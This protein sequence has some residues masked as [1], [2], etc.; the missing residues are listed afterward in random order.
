MKKR[1]KK[2]RPQTKNPMR[3]FSRPRKRAA[4]RRRPTHRN[5]SRRR[6]RNGGGGFAS[7]GI[8]SLKNGFWALVGLV[9]TR[10]LPQ[11]LLKEKNTGAMG[12]AANVAT[13]LA[14]SYVLGRSPAGADAGGAALIGGGLYVVNRV[15]SENFSPVGKFLSLQG[16]GDVNALGEILS[17][18]RTYFPLPVA[19]DNNRNPIIPTQI[20][21]RPLPVAAASGAGMGAWGARRRVAA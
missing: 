11:M 6:A 18:D 14:F 7:K 20:A 4:N 19:Y 3:S 21:A 15:I 8:A 12:Y 5:P 9:V 13:A 1:T 16:M 10:Q 17:G 2:R